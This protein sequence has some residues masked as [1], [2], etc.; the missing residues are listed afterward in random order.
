MTIPPSPPRADPLA[1]PVVPHV[2]FW[3]ELA[4]SE[5]AAGNVRL[6]ADYRQMAETAERYCQ[7]AY[8]ISC[9]EAAS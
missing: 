5:W 7:L 2:A 9:P 6:A 4:A 8:G 1:S 3:R